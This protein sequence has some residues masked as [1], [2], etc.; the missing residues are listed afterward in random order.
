MRSKV[1]F[2]GFSKLFI[3]GSTFSS[4]AYKDYIGGLPNENTTGTYIYS[5]IDSSLV[6]K[7]T[8]F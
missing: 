5:I 6:I 2:V 7:S 3:D 8:N 1:I 4:L